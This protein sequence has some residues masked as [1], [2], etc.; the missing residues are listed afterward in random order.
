ML[1][2]TAN[3][4]MNPKNQPGFEISAAPFTGIVRLTPNCARLNPITMSENASSR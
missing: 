2:T 3:A 1:Q 4:K